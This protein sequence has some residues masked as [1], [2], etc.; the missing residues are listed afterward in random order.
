MDRARDNGNDNDYDNYYHLFLFE[1]V[2]LT[3][4]FAQH[5]L[6]IGFEYIYIFLF[7]ETEKETA[8]VAK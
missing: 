8:V 2:L 7:F 6:P 1:S 5:F 3:G 4:K